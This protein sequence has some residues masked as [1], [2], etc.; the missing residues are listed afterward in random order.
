MDSRPESSTAT[1]ESTEKRHTKQ[2]KRTQH[3]R[4]AIKAG[5]QQWHNTRQALATSKSNTAEDLIG[6]NDI[7]TSDV[8]GQRNILNPN[9][10][11]PNG[12]PG[13]SRFLGVGERQKKSGILAAIPRRLPISIPDP[14]SGTPP[15]MMRSMTFK[16]NFI[17]VIGRLFVWLYAAA[18]FVG[19]TLRDSLLRRNTIQRRAARLSRTFEKAGGTFIKV[20]QQL[21][22]RLDLLSWTY[23]IE[24]SKLLDK[25][26][27]FPTEKAI[28]A[29]ER[30][31]GKPLDE[32]F[33]VFDPEPV[34]SASMACVYQ[35]YLKNGE[36]VVVKVRRPGIA[37]LFT[38]DLKALDWFMR[39]LEFLTILRVGYT[40]NIR[41]E[42]ATIFQE[43]LNFHQEGRYQELFRR[44]AKKSGKSFFSAPRVYPDLSG[45][46]ILVQ[47]FV[48]GVWLMEIL[49][50][51]D[52]NDKEALAYLRHLNID[53]KVLAKRL[54][55]VNS[56]GGFE[57]I[58]FHADPHPANIL[59]QPNNRLVFID[60]GACG[61]FSESRREIFRNFIFAEGR[62]DPEGMVQAAMALLEPLP[63]I[64]IYE[65]SKKL[66]AEYW[67][68]LY[69]QKSKYSEWWERGT[70]QT[71]YAFFR[72]S[73]EYKI[74][75]NLD[76][77]RLIRSTLLYDTLVTR[78]YPKID[79]N[80]EIRKYLDF[81]GK[82]ARKRLYKRTK[83]SIEKGLP[84]TSYQRFEQVIAVG[85]RILFRLQG[86]LN[87]PAH[88]FTSAISKSISILI[89][90][91]SIAVQSVF[92]AGII[93]LI[94]IVINLIQGDE[95]RL[96]LAFRDIA[97]SPLYQFLIGLLIFVQSR[98]I[99]YR[100]Q[101]KEP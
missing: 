15:P 89:A 70:I 25:M 37:K 32:T 75:M 94:A 61:S 24:L 26:Q 66:E 98:H 80:R 12:F 65:F 10:G 71:W 3:V 92:L 35:A 21:S 55:W 16:T 48:S 23:C 93:A 90:F 20:G 39:L 79:R 100:L 91:I 76:T 51:I 11:L 87:T 36:Q 83:R 17:R 46:D 81:S 85:N 52:N 63:Y 69:A 43:E 49:S 59:V 22:M 53:S 28:E 56:W 58:F 33:A 7:L 54:L 41:N 42:L 9:G 96:E 29:I 19:G 82:R 2:S 38:A 31:T 86:F 84:G 44:R 74:P 6:S 88:R 18:Y 45:E 40:K 95:I 64:D 50:A 8:P 34:G 67:K 13:S 27:P 30:V 57:N 47:E 5:I 1:T 99:Y 4:R 14:T 68:A 97:T 78:L 101:D 72:L 60:F 77:L 62:E 73:Q